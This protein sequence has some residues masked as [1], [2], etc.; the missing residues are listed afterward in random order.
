M[1]TLF[2]LLFI[3]LSVNLS[4]GNDYNIQTRGTIIP[5]S[6]KLLTGKLYDF[7][8]SYDTAIF[9]AIIKPVIYEGSKSGNSNVQY[10]VDK[11][12]EL[13]GILS[14]LHPVSYNPDEMNPNDEFI[15][16]AGAIELYLEQKS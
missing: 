14:E 1:K 5:E 11:N 7:F 9:R 4:F 15:V 3:L 2:G 10:M 12:R 13:I 6:R 8:K 16:L